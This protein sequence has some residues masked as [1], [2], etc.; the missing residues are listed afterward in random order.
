MLISKTQRLIDLTIENYTAFFQYLQKLLD[1]FEKVT[2]DALRPYI[3]VRQGE[4]RIDIPKPFDLPAFNPIYQ[5]PQESNED[6]QQKQT[7]FAGH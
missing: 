1:W 6:L 4:L 2:A 3:A 5:A 7:S